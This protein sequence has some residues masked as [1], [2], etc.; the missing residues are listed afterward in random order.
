MAAAARPEGALNE[1]FPGHPHP[2][3][4]KSYKCTP[5]IVVTILVNANVSIIV[6]IIVTIL[7][8]ATMLVHVT[9]NSVYSVA[10]Q[11]DTHV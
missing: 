4:E 3:P 7:V 10:K 8:N 9:V 6:T 11:E 1:Q 5:C 2:N